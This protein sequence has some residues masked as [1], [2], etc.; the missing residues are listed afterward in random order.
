M[1]RLGAGRGTAYQ[2]LSMKGMVG[3]KLWRVWGNHEQDGASLGETPRLWWDDRL[4]K[5]VIGL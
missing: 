3:E 4:G 5:V 2:A 1:L